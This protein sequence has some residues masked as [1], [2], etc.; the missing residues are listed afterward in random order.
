M[1][2]VAVTLASLLVVLILLGVVLFVFWSDEFKGRGV[3]F[4]ISLLASLAED[5]IFFAIVGIGAALVTLRHPKFDTLETKIRF[6]FPDSNPSLA[7]LDYARLELSRL[8]GLCVEAEQSIKVEEFNSDYN[9]YRVMF[10][11]RY[12]LRNMFSNHDYE[13]VFEAFVNPDMPKLPHT[14][15]KVKGQ[16]IEL[17]FKPFEGYATEHVVHPVD[18]ESDD[19]DRDVPLRLSPHQEGEI[20]FKFWL[21]CCVDETHFMR[22]KRFVQDFR[23]TLENSSSGV[24]R[25]SL[26]GKRAHCTTILPK[27]TVQLAN[28]RNVRPRYIFKVWLH[29]PDASV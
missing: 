22:A 26:D 11:Y 1:R 10:S 17:A 23:S 5:I 28:S 24:V 6:F 12:R 19:F 16:V 8:A 25:V 13:D 18:I 21:W 7:Y 27:Q 29:H 4:R 3:D 14:L 15:P 20:I 9:A 2:R